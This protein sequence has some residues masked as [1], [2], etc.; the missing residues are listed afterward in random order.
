MQFYEAYDGVFNVT[1][2]IVLRQKGRV[3]TFN[4]HFRAGEL[5]S[6]YYTDNMIYI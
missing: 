2:L 1:H 6:E 4:N 5:P 3:E